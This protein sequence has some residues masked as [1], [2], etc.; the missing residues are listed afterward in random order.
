MPPALS[1]IIVSYN[2]QSL[3]TACLD[4]VYQNIPND[5]PIEVIVVDNHSKEGIVA[6]LKQNYPQVI[7]IA[8][9]ENRGFAKANNQGIKIAGGEKIFLLNNDTVVIG[10]ALVKMARY[11]DTHPEIGLLGPKLLN[12]DGSIQVQGSMLGPHFWNSTVPTTTSFLRGAALMMRREI[13]EKV[14]LLDERFF[15]YN[16]DIDYCWRVKRSGFQLIYYP[17][18]EIT[19]LGGKTSWRRQWLGLKASWALWK[20]YFL[21]F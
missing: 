19:H 12:A 10:D 14:G 18:A 3:I 1:I 16:E 9:P 20:K 21:R 7:I 11:L 6:F 8:N 15:F 2:N 5:F 4:S 17:D 13:I